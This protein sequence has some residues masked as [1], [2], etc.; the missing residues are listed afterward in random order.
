MHLD[1]E[2]GYL[3]QPTE[4]F[5]LISL[6]LEF[7]TCRH[8]VKNQGQQLD[9]LLVDGPVNDAPPLTVFYFWVG[10]ISEEYIYEFQKLLVKLCQ[11][12]SK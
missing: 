2:I 11:L 1:I 3:M 8:V 10:S 9:I 7:A 4:E 5:P 12:T 6:P